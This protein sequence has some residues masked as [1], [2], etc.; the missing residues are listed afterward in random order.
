MNAKDKL[1]E[2]SKVRQEK[3]GYRRLFAD[4]YFDL[5]IWYDSKEKMSKIGFQLVYGKKSKAITWSQGSLN[6][7]KIEDEGWYNP[8][9]V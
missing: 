6:H 5:Y 2:F 8:S 9:P 3:E 4:D 1:K 7:N